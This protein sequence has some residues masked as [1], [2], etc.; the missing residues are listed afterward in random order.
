MKNKKKYFNTNNKRDY[1]VAIR[2]LITYYICFK[3]INN[4]MKKGKKD[5]AVRL[6]NNVLI[7]WSINLKSL[8]NNKQNSFTLLTKVIYNISLPFRLKK[9]RVAGRNLSIPLFL[10][11]K[12][13][14]NYGVRFLVNNSRERSEKTF[15]LSLLNEMLD[16][17]E[18]NSSSISLKKKKEILK[19]AIENKYYIKYL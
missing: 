2:V 10:L 5:T 3:L 12:K 15:T 4:I 13:Q 1:K 7:L 8:Y 19:L 18:N 16:I 11:V 6:L 14:L 9:K 17:S